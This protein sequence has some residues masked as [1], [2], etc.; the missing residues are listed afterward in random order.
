MWR[1]LPKPFG[2]SSGKNGNDSI[3]MDIA[4]AKKIMGRGFIGPDELGGVSAKL[5]IA[6]VS[7]RNFRIPPITMTERSLRKASKDH[8]LILG[9]PKTRNGKKLTL[10]RMRAHLGWNPAVSEPCFYNQDWYLKEK[11]AKDTTLEARWYLVRKTVVNKSRGKFPEAATAHLER[12]ETVP[13]AIVTA[14]AF[15]A[16]YFLTGGSMLWEHDFV[17]CAD[18]DSN[19]DRV[20]TGRYTDQKGVNKHGFNVHRHLSIRPCYGIAPMR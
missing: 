11:F 14:F 4:Y 16:Y 19:G 6:D 17:W 8:L 15:F 20:Y 13:P 18:K 1:V 2:T 12:G 3:F 5:G 10:N 7:R 9:V